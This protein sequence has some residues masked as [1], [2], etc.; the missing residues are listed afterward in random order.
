M[1]KSVQITL[2]IAAAIVMLGILA[3]IFFRFNSTDNTIQVNGQATS[4]VTPDLITV[5]FSIETTGTT[6]KEAE[7]ANTLISSKL[8]TNIINLGFS[9][10]DLKTQSINIYPEYDYSSGQ[11]LL[12]YKASNSMKIQ[13]PISKKDKISSVI[14]A[15]TNAGAGISYINFELTPQLQQ[16][17]KTAAIKNASDDAKVKAQAVA[18]GFNK[19]LGRLV[20]VSLDNF[21]YRPWPIYASTVSGVG[22]G[23]EAKSAAMNINPSEQEV[24]ASVT[25]VYKLN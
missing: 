13:I 10:N 8:T 15:G 19:R 5:Y 21:D 7:D 3:F 4:E 14:D 23:A 22:S 20:S 9:E 1:Q 25:A 24:S 16:S 11:K 17:A 6:L 12:D 2:I 18:E